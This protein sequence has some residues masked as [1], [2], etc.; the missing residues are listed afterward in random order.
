MKT[1]ISLAFLLSAL[2]AFAKPSIAVVNV[3]EVLS[4]YTRKAELESKFREQLEKLKTTPRVTAAQELDT[5]LKALAQVIQN[6]KTTTNDREAASAKF[7]SLRIEYNSLA[8]EA[9]RFINQEETKL[10]QKM[11]FDLEELMVEVRAA[12][13]VI[14]ETEGVDL[15]LENSGNT[16]SQTPAII[17]IRESIDLTEKVITLLNQ[18]EEQ[19]EN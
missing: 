6:E 10:K 1:L 17:Y 7:K 19:A 8:Q 9:S 4:K 15:V 3:D 11:L 18:E 14:S 16:S 5:E 2:A 13:N 12:I